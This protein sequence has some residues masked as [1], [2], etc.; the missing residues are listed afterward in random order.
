MA[1]GQKILL[2][3]L[4]HARELGHQTILSV[5]APGKLT[6]I[7][8]REDIPVHYLSFKRTFYFHQA[9][10]FARYLKN[11]QVGLVWSHDMVSGNIL[12]R[13]G[14]KL[15]GVPIFSEIHT[16]NAFSGNRLISACQ[17]R[18]DNRTA[19]FCAKLIAISDY[20]KSSLIRQ[21]Y[22][23]NLIEVIHNGI[24]M[25]NGRP[26]RS[27]SEILAELKLPSDANFVVCVGRLCKVKGQSVL[28]EAFSK[29][30][31]RYPN[32]VVLFIGEDLEAKG[33]YASELKRLAER[34]GIEKKSLFLGYRDDVRSYIDASLFLVLPSFLEGLPMAVLEAMALG[35]AVIATDVGGAS[36]ALLSGKT[37]WLAPAGD[38]EALAEKIASFLEHPQEASRMGQA[39]LARVQSGF[40]KE[41]MLRSAAKLLE[42]IDGAHRN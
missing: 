34:F 39:G 20:T 11:N 10:Q 18:L 29:I 33:A 26:H 14:A 5:P 21:G 25:T 42:E 15:A 16:D 4:R 7:A 6:E 28:L 1:G 8:E 17:R 36:E 22:P 40:T 41:A 2:D 24:D 9:L 13:I 37:G 30:A 23:E 31:G 32:T 27:K 3:I 12:S 19:R 35:K 38:I